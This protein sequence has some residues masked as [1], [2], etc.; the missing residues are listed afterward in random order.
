MKREE[1][2]LI[3]KIQELNDA[4]TNRKEEHNKTVDELKY[5]FREKKSQVESEIQRLLEIEAKTK[6]QIKRRV[7]AL[8][9]ELARSQ[10]HGAGG[11][12]GPPSVATGAPRDADCGPAGATPAGP[13]RRPPI[14]APGLRDRAARQPWGGAPRVP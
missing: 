10:E 3:M 12:G 11:D 4:M 13:P 9:E 5:K 7:Q 8:E 6:E 2:E 14:R 1:K